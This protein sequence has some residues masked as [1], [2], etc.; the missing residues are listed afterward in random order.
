MLQPSRRPVGVDELINFTP[1]CSPRAR[2]IEALFGSL[3]GPV[4]HAPKSNG[5]IT[6]TC[7]DFS[8][9]RG[10]VSDVLGADLAARTTE[11]STVPSV[12]IRR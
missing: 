3:A 5:S 7:L 8:R 6:T 4:R 2:R 9:E 11:R 12:E 1:K 10:R